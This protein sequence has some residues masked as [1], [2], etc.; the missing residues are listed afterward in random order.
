MTRA[1]VLLVE[2]EAILAMDMKAR[3]QELGHRVVAVLDRAEKAPAAVRQ[4]RPDV[5]LMD[6]RTPGA[7][8]GIEAADEIARDAVVPVVFVTAFADPET[9]TRATSSGPYGYLVKPVEDRELYATLE[10]VLIK[11]SMWRELNESRDQLAR[12]VNE[13]TALNKLFQRQLTDQFEVVDAFRAMSREV[14]AVHRDITWAL[15]Q[16]NAVNVPVYSGAVDPLALLQRV[17]KTDEVIAIVKRHLSERF[18]MTDAFRGLFK[19]LN[20]LEQ[21]IGACSL[22]ADEIHIPSF[23]RPGIGE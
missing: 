11:A 12:K 4:F 2:D 13:L 15:D 17:N 18:A 10:V 5:V 16:A 8:D 20:E 19:N 6:I 3:L 14:K 1:D 21:R 23:D 22:R 7:I 9:L